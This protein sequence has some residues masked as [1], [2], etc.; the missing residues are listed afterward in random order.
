M[1]R[2]LL[3]ALIEIRRA[4]IPAALATRLES[5]EQA[6]ITADGR[7]GDAGLAALAADAAHEAIR[8][9]R[10]TTID[11]D[12]G[13]VFIQVFNPPLRLVIVGAV[14]IA[15]SLVP[16]AQLAGY[17]VTVI[18]PRRAFAT[19]TRFPGLEISTD[20]PDEALRSLEPDQRTALVTLT[21]DP[22]IDDPALRVALRSNIFYIGSLG[23]PRT[24][25]RRLERLREAGFGD[26]ALA[27][28][29]GP[30]GLDIGARS[31]AEIAIAI[32]AQITEVL[33]RA[34]AKEQAA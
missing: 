31:P 1:K 9:D 12:G 18:D 13:Q 24:H 26:A 14:H 30:V 3:D 11:A 25:G 17:Q 10:S 29:H 2:K 23:S 21:H 5:G 34:P 28:I 15:Q 16:M 8:H 20:W 32:L 7:L 27:R 19:E 33:H 22:K 6:L 4:K